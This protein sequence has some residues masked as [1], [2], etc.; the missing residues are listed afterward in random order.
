VA[1]GLQYQAQA[2]AVT[3]EIRGAVNLTVLDSR[4]QWS[5]ALQQLED[6]PMI[7]KRTFLAWSIA[8]MSLT[9]LAFAQQSATVTLKSGERLSTQLVDLSGSGY[10]VRV[11]GQERQIGQNDVA[12][13]DF[14][15]DT[16]STSD[17]DKLNSGGQVLIL[18]SGENLTGQLVD[19][20]GTSPLRMTFRTSSGERDFSSNDIA[21]IVM[22]RPDNVPAASTGVG[23]TG[24]TPAQGVT[25][26]SQQPWTA[27]GIAV[28][29]G[30]WVT[31]STSGDVHIGGDG[32]P[33]AGPDGVSGVLAPGAPLANAPAGAL[34]GRVGSGAVFMIG[35]RNRIQ[36]PAAGQLFL[37]VNDGHLPDNNGAFQVQVAREGGTLRRQ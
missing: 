14:A 22:T 19:I 28:R 9:G 6:E 35:S 2:L 11:N 5:E 30:D 12:A 29:R 24:S 31:F 4:A 3:D 8:A 1:F 25:V 18:K 36:M 32:D 33:K 15:G 21:R 27:T 10:T 7:M 16:I 37:G 17:W 34:I 20:G 26:S 23:N 13:I